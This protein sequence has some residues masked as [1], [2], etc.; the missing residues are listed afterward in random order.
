M[1]IMGDS[2]KFGFR[3]KMLYICNETIIK[4]KYT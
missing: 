4:Y 1:V 2:R 3:E